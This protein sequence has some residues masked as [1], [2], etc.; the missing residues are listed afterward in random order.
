MEKILVLP[1]ALK[2]PVEAGQAA[3]VLEYRLGGEKLGELPVV[4]ESA[5][6]EARLGDYMRKILRAWGMN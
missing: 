1:E 2:A 4:T 5:V 3:G 6:K